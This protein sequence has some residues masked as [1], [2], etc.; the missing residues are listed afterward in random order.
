MTKVASEM[1]GFFIQEEASDSDG[2]ASTSEGVF[3]YSTTFTEFP[4]VGDAVR[5][6]GAVAEYNG[7][8]EIVL[9][10]NAEVLGAG[11]SILS[12]NLEMPFDESVNLE[13]FEG[14]Q[15]SFQQTLSVTDIY[16][17]GRY[18]QFNVSS[19]RLMI[20]TN[21]YAAGSSEAIALAESNGRNTLLIDDGS[22]AQNA[23]GIPFPV[24]GLSHDNPLRLGDSVE[25]LEG[26]MHYAFGAYNLIPVGDLQ[27]V[28]T[29]PRTDAPQLDVQGDVKVASF[30]VL[31]YFNGPNFPTSRGADS[32]TEFARQQAKTVAA[33]V[34]M[35]A[36]VVGLV[37]IENDGYGSDSAIAS[38]VDS[39]NAEI[40]S[41]VYSY[42]AL[43]S[44]LGG[45][46]IAVGIIYKPAT[47]TPQGAAVTSSDTPFDYGNRQPLL[48]SF[49]VNS[50]DEAFTLAVNHF[51]SKGSCG[52][53]TGNDADSGDGQ[54]CWN[55][56]RTQAAEGLIALVQQNSE[57]LSDRV[58]VMGD[59]NAYAKEDPILAL[60]SA[61]YSNLVNV[62]DGDSAYSYSF[63]GEMG[64]L[65]HA[66]SSSSLTEYV[67]DATVWHIN[68]DE[69]RVFD[70]NV[71]YKTETQ[72]SSYYGADAY[73]SSDHDPVV[74]V[75]DFPETS[76]PE[77]I[78]GDFDGDSDVDNY[79]VVAFYTLLLRNQATV[80]EHDFNGDSRLNIYDLYAL[81]SMCTRTAC[82][83]Q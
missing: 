61:G 1:N 28:R 10:A 53:A 16:N 36:D 57:V 79:D 5:V 22:N 50:N 46:E 32:E 20:P 82:A 44:L 52:S 29:N 21:Q 35:D 72:L 13:S 78:V 73:R 60:E 26:V 55:E 9:S 49:S 41:D 27:T 75:I 38:L 14:M 40:G 64:Y 34:A 70:Y 39:V 15:V 19:G 51:K 83:V 37:E 11:D 30:N 12:T 81:M 74:V 59:L 2:N 7:I 67:V 3:V 65:D 25:G 45:D 62:F 47:V 69:P 66:L 6:S 4:S 68:A 54:G 43:E 31:N 77:P 56:L 23:D 76:E 58:I 33:I 17:L 18:G 8:T 71:E 42:V 48:Q 80:E 63:G 24:G